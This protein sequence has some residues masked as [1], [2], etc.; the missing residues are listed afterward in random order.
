MLY[1]PFKDKHILLFY[2][3]CTYTVGGNTA[4][5]QIHH[6]TNNLISAVLYVASAVTQKKFY[7]QL[8]FQKNAF[9][10]SESVYC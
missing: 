10:N 4:S 8:N 5:F 1:L 3:K 9:N 6:R 7:K 2:Q